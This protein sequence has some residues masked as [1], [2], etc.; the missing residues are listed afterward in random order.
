[1]ALQERTIGRF[2]VDISLDEFDPLRI[3]KTSGVTAGGSS[4]L[5][6]KD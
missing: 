4:G 1:V 6:V 5:P 3:Q 2:L